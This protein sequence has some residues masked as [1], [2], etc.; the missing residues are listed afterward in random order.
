[1]IQNLLY[2]LM[3][4]KLAFFSCCL[5]FLQNHSV[6]NTI[7]YSTE[8]ITFN[9][10]E[11]LHT[12]NQPSVVSKIE[13]KEKSNNSIN[14]I[15]SLDQL[16]EYIQ[17]FTN[18]PL[19]YTAT[20]T[21]IFRGNSSAKIMLIGEAPG[22]DE[23]INGIP[24]CGRSGK[25]L[26]SILCSIGLSEKDVYI[27]N[28]LPWR[29]PNNR[30]PLESEIAMFQDVLQKHISLINP[31]VL[32][33]VGGT[34]LEACLNQNKIQ[35]SKYINKDMDYINEFMDRK[36]KMFAL[37]HPSYLLRSYKNKKETWKQMLRIKYLYASASS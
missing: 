17:N 33:C 32:I 25:L 18:C 11:K 35:I 3:K 19:R 30:K 29:P 13:T 21:V 24:F 10:I 4:S 6:L 1:M 36:I 8:S 37:Y 5:R 12:D 22:E 34:A 7:G 31:D 23:D 16:Y 2:R 14:F 28:V 27:T 9:N 26:D 20:N 15:T